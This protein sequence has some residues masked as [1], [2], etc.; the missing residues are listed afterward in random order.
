VINRRISSPWP[1]STLLHMSNFITSL[2][3]R[4]ISE[5]QVMTNNLC[6]AE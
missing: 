4:S 6:E 3:G 5:V 2:T 1:L